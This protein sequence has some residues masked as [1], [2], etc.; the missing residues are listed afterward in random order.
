MKNQQLDVVVTCFRLP[1][2]LVVVVLACFVGPDA[3]KSLPVASSLVG[4]NA[5]NSNPCA[6]FPDLCSAGGG[7]CV[8][9]VMLSYYR[10]ILLLLLL[11][12]LACS[13]SYGLFYVVLMPCVENIR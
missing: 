13:P 8:V 6:I 12:F 4:C 7:L 10:P 1:R 3:A 11:L 9:K 2:L 5:R